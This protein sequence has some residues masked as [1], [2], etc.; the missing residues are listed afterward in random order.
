MSIPLCCYSKEKEVTE[1]DA[2]EQV[3]KEE[4]SNK[5]KENNGNDGQANDMA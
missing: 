5:Y 1:A 2:D 4:R 3:E